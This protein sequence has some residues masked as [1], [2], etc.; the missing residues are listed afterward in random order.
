M[1]RRCFVTVGT[2]E[3]DAL[4]RAVLTEAVL[5]QL[6][7]LGITDMLIQYGSGVTVPEP[8]NINQLKVG[9]C[10]SA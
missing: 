4:I 9:Q 6:A 1:S 8:D 5:D 7:A 3:F 2:T 10:R